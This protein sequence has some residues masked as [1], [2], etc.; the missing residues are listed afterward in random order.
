MAATGNT[1]SGKPYTASFA[2]VDGKTKIPNAPKWTKTLVK[3]KD[4]FEEVPITVIRYESYMFA[5]YH[6]AEVSV[7]IECTCGKLVDLI[8]ENHYRSTGLITYE[9]AKLIFQSRDPNYSNIT[10]KDAA[11]IKKWKETKIKGSPL[12]THSFLTVHF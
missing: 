10:Y 4:G 1:R 7:D 6:K 9:P 8:Q 3:T 11:D 5:T 2:P 12:M